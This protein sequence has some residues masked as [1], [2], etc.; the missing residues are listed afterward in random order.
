MT[1]KSFR[2]IFLSS[3]ITL[4]I[5]FIIVVGVSQHYFV[6]TLTDD[7]SVEAQYAAHGINLSGIQYLEGLDSSHRI[8]LIGRDGSVLFDNQYDHD[9][10]ASHADRSEFLDALEHG[11]GS[12]SRYSF[13]AARQYLYH[14]VRLDDGNV[15]RVSAAYRSPISLAVSLLIPLAAAL[16]LMALLSYRLSRQLSRSI[17]R[18]AEAIDL[19]DPDNTINCPEMSPLLEK[20]HRLNSFIREHISQLSRKQEQF[21]VITENMSEG[22]IVVNRSREILS[23]NSSAIR[24]LGSGLSAG[25][26]TIDSLEG[27]EPLDSALAAALEGSHH[28]QTLDMD[29]ATYR[30]IANP[31]YHNS[32]ITGVVIVILDVTEKE[33]LEQMRKEFTSNVSH[34]LRT[35]LTAIRGASEMLSGGLVRPED[36]A[37]FIDTIHSESGRLMALIDDILRL[38]QLDEEG[39]LPE[40]TEIDLYALSQSV[41]ERLS[42]AAARQNVTVEVTGSRT[43][44]LG[45]PTMIEELVYNLCDNAIKYNQPEG[46]VNIRVGTLDGRSAVTVSDTGI[47]IGKE[48]MGRIFERFYRVDKSRSRALGGTG[49][50]LSIVKHAAV[51]HNADIRVESEEG[52]GTTMTI[53]F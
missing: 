19:D 38:S 5:T 29:G 24:I 3:V 15:I 9:G 7:I 40:K 45:V 10:L 36:T 46:S 50:G 43:I 6:S 12:A 17:R 34:E 27:C 21:A 39:I 11:S 48:H 4:M 35:P 28:E 23:Y 52:K 37:R 49:L 14:A 32:D 44:I 41:A 47:G 31:V 1:G 2:R 8:T 20:I 26:P 33:N 51:R 13:T 30:I 22:F 16:L 53:L 25:H 42:V 18:Q